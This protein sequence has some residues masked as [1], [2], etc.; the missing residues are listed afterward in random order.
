MVSYAYCN[1]FDATYLQSPWKVTG[2][3]PY[4]D[5]IDFPANFIEHDSTSAA[6]VNIGYFGF[7]ATPNVSA[8]D[9]YCRMTTSPV[10]FTVINKNG[11]TLGSLY[12]SSN[13][14]AWQQLLVTDDTPILFQCSQYKSP[15]NVL[16]IDCARLEYTAPAVAVVPIADGFVTCGM[17]KLPRKRVPKLVPFS[18]RFPKFAPRTVA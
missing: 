16:E 11:V 17:L 10:T 13:A 4:L 6:V 12:I 9:I 5:A 14:W 18:R 3:S 2:T 15:T 7:P 1:S 8:L